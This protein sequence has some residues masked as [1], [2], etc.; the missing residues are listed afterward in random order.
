MNILV[1]QNRRS[2]G[3]ASDR[4][5]GFVRWGQRVWLACICAA[6]AA[7]YAIAD[8]KG[9]SCGNGGPEIKKIEIPTEGKI[10]RWS[11]QEPEITVEPVW[12]GEQITCEFSIRNE[13]EALLEIKAAGG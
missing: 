9:A 5:G 3:A 1:S 13:G 8:D 6:L 4:T 10:P 7:G 2:T 11:C 12:R